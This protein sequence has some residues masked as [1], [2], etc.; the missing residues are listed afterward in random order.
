ME[1]K[2]GAFGTRK[3]IGIV[4]NQMIRNICVS[5]MQ[6]DVMESEKGG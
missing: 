4:F 3:A 6:I 5:E 1:A 2:P